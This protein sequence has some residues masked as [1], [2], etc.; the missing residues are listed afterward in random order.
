MSECFVAD[1]RHGLALFPGTE[2]EVMET[3]ERLE[4]NC[5][6]DAGGLLLA[7]V[8][9]EINEMEAEYMKETCKL[10][11]RVKMRLSVK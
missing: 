9:V 6:G 1:V 7:R 2:E 8:G 3:I 11:R 5:H 10:P 4:R